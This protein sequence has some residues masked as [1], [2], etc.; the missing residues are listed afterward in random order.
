MG[1]FTRFLDRFFIKLA[2][3]LGLIALYGAVDIT[4][5]TIVDTVV[6]HVIPYFQT[7]KPIYILASILCFF[8]YKME[9][10]H[11][12]R[13]ITVTETDIT[14]KMESQ[15]GDQARLSRTQKLRANHYDVTGYH[16]ELV[17]DVGA[18]IPRDRVRCTIDHC[19]ANQQHIEFNPGIP[20]NHST[21]TFSYRFDPI[22][23]I[24]WMLG[25]NSV[26]YQ[27]SAILVNAYTGN[28][29]Y[30]EMAIPVHYSYKEIM[31]SVLFHPN[32]I[33]PEENCTAV[34][35]SK[36]G[37]TDVNLQR[38]VANHDGPEG[39]RVRVKGVAGDR[40]RLTWTYPT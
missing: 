40:F 5:P 6:N 14:L 20:Q 37:I 2:I 26:N 11:K 33:A 19:D 31:I 38:I 28:T 16:R 39:I 24:L 9:I 13:P 34:K 12:N 23:R 36:N 3:P 7:L 21:Q 1:S 25:L 18:Q 27:E 30:Y 8:F 4:I 17:A 15:N 35:I 22:P 32:R 10:R 29:E